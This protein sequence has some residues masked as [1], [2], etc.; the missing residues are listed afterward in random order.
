M[1]IN[2]TTRSQ[3]GKKIQVLRRAGF[4][5]AVVYGEGIE[6]ESIAIAHKEFEK[7]YREAGESTLVTLNVDGK[8]Y[9]VLI[10]DVVYDPLKGMPIHADFYAVRMD[11]AIRRKVPLE[12]FGESPA[13]K[14]EGGIPVKVMQELE[15]EAFPQD[16]PHAL[17]VD[18]SALTSFEAKLFVRDVELPQGVKIFTDPEEIIFLI[19]TPRSDEE[20]AALREVSVAEGPAAVETEQEVKRKAKEVEE[21]GAEEKDAR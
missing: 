10:H 2:A 1:E 14:N 19:E 13:A 6:S 15:I 9:T 16:L 5:P 11:K 7:I 21:A 17:R 18:I 4:L 20:L 12:F 8:P 3:V